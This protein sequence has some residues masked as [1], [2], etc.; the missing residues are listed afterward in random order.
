V[1]VA[2]DTRTKIINSCTDGLEA[3]GLQNCSFVVD[4]PLEKPLK[5]NSAGNLRPRHRKFQVRRISAH[6]RSAMTVASATATG[7]SAGSRTRLGGQK[8]FALH[9]LARKLAGPAD[10]FR[11]LPRLLFRWFFIM[12]AKF[13]F[14]ENTL[15]LHLFLQRLQGLVDVVVA[16]ENLHACSFVVAPTG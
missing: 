1:S 5:N 14:A 6:A 3:I 10:R 2:T 16:N 11:L 12:T 8:A 9:L 13:H 7:A 4:F 15:A